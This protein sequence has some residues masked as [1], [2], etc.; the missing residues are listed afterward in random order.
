MKQY[1]F[2]VFST[3]SVA[4][5]DPLM[6]IG[7]GINAFTVFTDD[8]DAAVKLLEDE[9]CEVRSVTPL[10]A[11]PTSIQDLYLPGENDAG[12]PEEE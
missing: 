6:L 4:I 11:E 2:L 12:E 10:T 3:T 7:K 9:G 5:P 1:A 8:I